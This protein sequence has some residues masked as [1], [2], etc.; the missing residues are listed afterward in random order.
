MKVLLL[1]NASASSV[2]P[3]RQV[4]V[5][6]AFSAEHEVRMVETNRRGHA[7]QF[8]IDAAR[9]EMDVVVVLGG[10]GTLNEAANGLIGTNCALAALPGGSTNVFA[11]TLGLSDDLA[12][13]TRTLLDAISANSIM[14]IGLGS[15][16]GRHFLFHTGVGWDARLVREVEKRSE[17]KRHFGHPLFVWSGLQTFFRIYDRTTPHFRVIHED[18]TA[19]DDG[20]FS[21]ILNSNPYTYVGTRP[22]NL[23]PE[24]DLRRPLTAITVTDMR[25]LPFLRT[26]FTAL[27]RR[28]GIESV[29]GVD[30]R[31]D[32]SQLVIEGYGPVPYQVD[33]DDLGDADR[34]EFRHHPD[35]MDLVVPVGWRS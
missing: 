31:R 13:S 25:A 35:V 18:D 3:E 19:I 6:R 5:H 12:T 1:V 4:M 28:G 8:A 20:Y 2:T 27:F 23:D 9:Q 10:D 34:L 22:F 7:T 26:M 17:W 33:G 21:V 11:R 24:A 29:P 16:N 15:V 14:R 32:V 30:F